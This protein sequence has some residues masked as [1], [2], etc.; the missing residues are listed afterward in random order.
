[1]A[2]SVQDQEQDTIRVSIMTI[3]GE[4]KSVLLNGDRTVAAALRAGGFPENAEVR[5]AGNTYK[6]DDEL[7]DGDEATVLAGAKVKG[8]N[9]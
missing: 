2:K 8:G 1:M 4:I 7:E 6:G 3:G 9:A 5:V